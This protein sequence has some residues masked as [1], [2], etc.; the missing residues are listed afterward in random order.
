MMNSL[1]RKL[2]HGA[3]KNTYYLGL[4]TCNKFLFLNTLQ[5]LLIDECIS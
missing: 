3:I 1:V 5:S 4:S 2:F